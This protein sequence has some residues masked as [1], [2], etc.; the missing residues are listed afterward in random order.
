MFPGPGNLD[1][2]R[3]VHVLHRLIES[4]LIPLGKNSGDSSQLNI[5][6]VFRSNDIP[7]ISL[8]FTIDRLVRTKGDKSPFQTPFFS[9]YK[10]GEYLKHK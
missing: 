1:T 6:I 9:I 10:T 2:M 8:D 4:T 7:V 3:N 5:L